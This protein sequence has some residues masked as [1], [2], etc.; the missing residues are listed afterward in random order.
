MS[1]EKKFQNKVTDRGCL[2]KWLT[3]IEWEMIKTLGSNVTEVS[4]E[5]KN[6]LKLFARTL[7]FDPVINQRNLKKKSSGERA[8]G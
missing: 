3:S 4:Q 1:F 6:I 2:D 5:I 7:S 8:R